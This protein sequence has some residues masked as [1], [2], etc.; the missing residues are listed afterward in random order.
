MVRQIMVMIKTVSNT[1]SPLFCLSVIYIQKSLKRWKNDF[2]Q[3][4][5]RFRFYTLF[6]SMQILFFFW[7]Y[8]FCVFWFV[9]RHSFKPRAFHFQLNYDVWQGVI[10]TV[11]QIC[12]YFWDNPHNLKIDSFKIAASEH[13]CIYK[14][15]WSTRICLLPHVV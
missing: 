1:N 11:P 5:K 9:K 14:C 4:Q 8:F 15:Y 12:A 2:L 13:I 3:L 10:F 6:I 7:D